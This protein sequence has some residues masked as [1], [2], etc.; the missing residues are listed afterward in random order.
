MNRRRR[1]VLAVATR[2]F[3]EVGYEATTLE[4]IA[5]EL[6]LSKPGLYYY[7]KSKEDVLVQ[8]HQDV[9]QNVMDQVQAS[10]TPEMPPDERLWRL[11]VVH[12]ITLCSHPA[13]QIFLLYRGQLNRNLD[14]VALRDRYQNLIESIVVEGIEQGIFHVANAKLSAFALLG[15]LN[16]IPNWY[17]PEGS[18]SLGE[19]GEYFANIL[20][21]GLKEPLGASFDY[22]LWSRQNSFKELPNS[23]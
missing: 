16:W 7:I 23:L 1:E 2:L 5:D 6:A 18:L 19:I 14:I 17:S 15:A 3:A 9:V 20:V 13:R 22:P 4:M 10:I 8:I 21:G 11:I 12:A